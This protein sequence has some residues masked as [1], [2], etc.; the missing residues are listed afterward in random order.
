MIP[1]K[2]LVAILSVATLAACDRV[3]AKGVYLIIEFENSA[4]SQ[5]TV[6]NPD[7]RSLAECKSS[8][9]GAIPQILASA[10]IEAARNSRVKSWRCSLTPPEKGG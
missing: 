2:S 9:A 10:P 6:F 3:E 7:V 1:V 4:V 5:Y 8:A